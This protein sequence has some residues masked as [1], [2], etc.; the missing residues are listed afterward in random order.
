MTAKVLSSTGERKRR[1]KILCRHPLSDARNSTLALIIATIT[2]MGCKQARHRFNYIT[3][4]F[5]IFVVTSQRFTHFENSTCSNV[6]ESESCVTI[7]YIEADLFGIETGKI[8]FMISHD[9][10]LLGVHVTLNPFI[11]N[12]DY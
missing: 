6:E 12:C 3:N 2:S 4:A 10:F 7:L 1:P 9:I 11:N 5:Q 8:H